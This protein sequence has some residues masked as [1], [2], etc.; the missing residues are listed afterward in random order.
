M[1]A[2]ER[3]GAPS[4]VHQRADIEGQTAIHSHIHIRQVRV[5]NQPHIPVFALPPEEAGGPGEKPRNHEERTCNL[6][7]ERPNPSRVPTQDHMCVF[8]HFFSAG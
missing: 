3:R 8:P 7:T 1:T 4:T 6:C 2:A 5:T